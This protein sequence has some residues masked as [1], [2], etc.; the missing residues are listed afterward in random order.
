MPR[1]RAN[2]FRPVA[3]VTPWSSPARRSG[4]AAGLALCALVVGLPGHGLSAQ[5][6]PAATARATRTATYRI[7]ATLDPA[8]RLMAGREVITWRNQTA[9]PTSELRLHLYY[10]AWRN[11]RSSFL[12]SARRSVRAP[13][14]ADYGPNDW[15][16]CDITAISVETAGGAAPLTP[17]FI[18]PDDGNEDDRT[19][20]QVALPT[21][22]APGEDVTLT[23]AWTLKVPRPFQRVGV[24]GDYFLIGHWFPKIGVY[25]ADG[26]WRAHQFI[27][28]EFFADFAEYDVRLTVPAGWKV[29]ATGTRTGEPQAR[30]GLVTHAFQ[31]ADVHDFA[32]TTSPRYLVLTDRF[33]HPGLPPVDL[34]LLLMPDHAA[35]AERYFAS[36]KLG[37]RYYGTWFRPY[38]WNRLTI[39]DP[40]SDSNTG[41][42]EYPMFVTGEA[43]WLTQPG[44]RLTEA[45]TLHE[46]GHQWWQGAVANDE[47]VD[48]FLDEGLN[49][50]AH[51]RIVDVAYP[52]YVF[53][54]RYFRDYIPATFAD[55][56]RPQVTHGA[57]PYDGFRSP[58]TIETMATPAFRY[59]ERAYFILPYTKGA[60]MFVTLER[61]LGWTTWQRV[62]KTYAERFWFRQPTP[63]DLFAVVTEVSGQDLTWFFD[64]VYR[65]T[66]QFDYAVDRV[67]TVP[68]GAPRGYADGAADWTPGGAAAGQG[69]DSTV[70][71]RRWGGGVFPIDVRVTFEDGSRV[72]ERWDG[73]ARWTRF[74]YRA[75]P[76]VA[77]VEIDPQRV[78]VL[79]VNSTNN[80]WTRRPA[81]A[82]AATKWTAKW[83]I[84]LQGVLELAVFFS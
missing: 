51:R 26:T 58:L 33:E 64:Q 19:L 75:R 49:T 27:Q 22:V 55:L 6:L 4:L 59:D 63:A 74:T 56:P 8:R 9:H 1:M 35:L 65:G 68:V 31:A 21:A 3:G 5:E 14:L 34:E 25:A 28:T 81:A 83:L 79:D 36:A 62:L 57:D 20:V 29:G 12:R 60:L 30:D 40:P 84:W 2:R 52:P 53:E 48:A 13:N 69:F 47:V 46:V 70:D 76:R 11:D 24:I 80:T 77:T 71:V 18:Q 39:V 78:L 41:G 82:E 42:M 50:W 38:A 15:A 45:N 43:R 44:N 61:H 66:D 16:F 32:W 10:N 67:G 23:V 54:K 72:T 73:R 17:R 37:L 7:D